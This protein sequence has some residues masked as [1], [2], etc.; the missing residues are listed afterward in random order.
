MYNG[1]RRQRSVKVRSVTPGKEK[2]ILTRSTWPLYLL[3][4]R[5]RVKTTP[6]GYYIYYTYSSIWFIDC[7]QASPL[8]T[9]PNTEMHNLAHRAVFNGMR[10]DQVEV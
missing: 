10:E 3:T 1:M 7:R 4:R 9:D 5:D 8:V 2:P 6:P